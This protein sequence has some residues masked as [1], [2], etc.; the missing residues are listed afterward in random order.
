[1]DDGDDMTSAVIKRKLSCVDKISKKMTRLGR[2]TYKGNSRNLCQ[3]YKSPSLRK[4]PRYLDQCLS[5]RGVI[6]MTL[7]S[8]ICQ[9]LLKECTFKIVPRGTFYMGEKKI[10]SRTKFSKSI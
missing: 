6:L 1:M 8:A 10:C 5:P 4:V 3:I 9:Y 7:Y 2:P